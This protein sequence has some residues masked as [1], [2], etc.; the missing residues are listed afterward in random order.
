MYRWRIIIGPSF[1]AD[2]WALL[3]ESPELTIAVVARRAYG[4]FAT[5]WTV[6]RD[7]A[8]ARET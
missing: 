8:V 4:S 3:E 5:A 6:K 2:M 1:R 7:W